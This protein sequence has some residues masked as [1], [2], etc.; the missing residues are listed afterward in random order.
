MATNRKTAKMKHN[1]FKQRPAVSKVVNIL[2][3]QEILD[4]IID[5]EIGEKQKKMALALERFTETNNKGK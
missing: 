3:S 2:P 1:Y 4:K 5:M